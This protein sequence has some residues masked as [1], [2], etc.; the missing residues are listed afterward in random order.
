MQG[1]HK[2]G[3][4]TAFR[5]RLRDKRR[6]AV[7]RAS[8]TNPSG[9]Q[10]ARVCPPA[11][12]PSLPIACRSKPWLPSSWC[13]ANPIGWQP[14]RPTSRLWRCWQRWAGMGRPTGCMDALWVFW[15]VHSCVAECLNSPKSQ[16]QPALN[17]V[18]YIMY[19]IQSTVNCTMHRDSS[20][21]YVPGQAQSMR[22]WR[23]QIPGFALGTQRSA[24]RLV[25][26]GARIG[27]PWKDWMMTSPGPRAPQGPARDMQFCAGNERPVGWLWLVPMDPG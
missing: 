27:A 17:S 1:E 26:A 16:L 4:R 2:T 7:P 13:V 18:L 22:Y 8:G 14:S 11:A 9:A 21:A 10:A 23:R 12:H 15:S 24:T 5:G 20:P 19:R 6:V 3:S 25:S